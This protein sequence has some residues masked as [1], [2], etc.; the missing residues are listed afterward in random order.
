[1]P[2]DLK[3]FS[4]AWGALLILS[5]ASPSH[6]ANQYQVT[7]AAQ[8]LFYKENYQKSDEVFSKMISEGFVAGLFDD[9]GRS[10]AHYYRAWSRLY[11]DQY[12]GAYAD[13]EFLIGRGKRL[14]DCYEINAYV[15]AL[16]NERPQAESYY[17]RIVKQRRLAYLAKLG[18]FLGHAS[19]VNARIFSNDIDGAIAE[20]NTFLSFELSG[21]N[22][23]RYADKKKYYRELQAMLE[24]LAA[25][26][27]GNLKGLIAE[28]KKTNKPDNWYNKH[29]LKILGDKGVALAFQD[30][31]DAA[32]QQKQAG[33]S[34]EALKQYAT[35]YVN[36][37]SIDEANMAFI[38]TEQMCQAK[39]MDA[40][41][42]EE[43]RRYSIQSGTHNKA[44]RYD[45]ARAVYKKAIVAKPCRGNAYFS[46]ASSYAKEKDYGRA[47]SIMK[48]YLV[49]SDDEKKA[50]KGQDMIYVWEAELAAQK[51]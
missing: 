2:F 50:R 14:H 13:C 26:D 10:D 11:L 31:M 28:F 22:E 30:S 3:R 18:A 9:G 49:L 20:I 12:D 1:M 36:A 17:E 21:A 6:A 5:I 44:K 35:A 40:E 34:V 43:T 29:I 7:R 37:G 51:Q 32:E 16:K 47:I 15:H 25:K 42:N 27:S 8:D 39:V 46:L 45:L 38:H 19:V 33:A 48:H 23:S 4:A 41:A 24:A